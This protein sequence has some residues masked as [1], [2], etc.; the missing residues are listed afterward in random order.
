MDAV[1][2]RVGVGGGDCAVAAAV[3]CGSSPDESLWR[4][5]ARLLDCSAMK[6]KVTSFRWGQ[7]TLPGQFLLAG[8]VV[9]LLTMLVVGSWVSSRIEQAVVQN[10]AIAAASY[11]ESFISPLSQDLA[12]QDRLSEPAAQA[13]DEIFS[14]VTMQ[15]RVVSYKIWK[16]GGRVVHASDR[17]VIGKSF[18]PSDD[19]RA[20]WQGEVAASYEN[21]NDPE[22]RSEA[23]LGVPLL[24]VYSP[25]H[26][27]WSGRIIAV[28]EFYQRADV[29][30]TDLADAKRKSWLIVGSAFLAS[31]FLLFGIVQAGGRTIRHQRIRLEEQLDATKTLAAQNL[32]LRQR[33]VTASARATAQTER[34]IRRI[35]S[36]LHDGPGQ[37]LS[38]AA[39][40]LD[41][42]LKDQADS[43]ASKD[44]RNSLQLALEEIRAISRGLSLPDLD[45]ID[46]QTLVSRA[47]RQ[48]EEQTTMQIAT[49]FEGQRPPVVGYAEKLCIYRFLQEALSN[50]FRHAD[51]QDASVTVIGLA[52]GIKVVV[53]DKG[54]GFDPSKVLTLRR[55][56]GQGLLGLMDRAESIGG[57][58]S[59]ESS[60]GKGSVLTL[61]L[62]EG[63]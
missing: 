1:A 19:L 55:D 61:T 28:A 48:H 15:E 31:G 26:E 57:S 11:M 43:G 13:L 33:A 38:L 24:E 25:I 39:L 51:V 59:I 16:G 20:A 5:L 37:H 56:G 47:V 52:D 49:R 62:L 44:I 53:Q 2:G 63:E 8:A 4:A 12:S 60:H 46:L 17:S 45:Q 23:A 22:D 21:L 54:V 35:G 40:R 32:A 18:K 7:L 6:A 9:M 42:A 27:I 29:L 50:S 58:I 3:A 10:S 30:K 34:T 36:D 41:A 14:G